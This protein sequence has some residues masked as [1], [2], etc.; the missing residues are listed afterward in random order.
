MRYSVIIARVCFGAALESRVL[1]LDFLQASS[2][3]QGAIMALSM[4]NEDTNYLV[5]VVPQG[6]SAVKDDNS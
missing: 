3:A 5:A 2:I 1:D 4:L 6:Y